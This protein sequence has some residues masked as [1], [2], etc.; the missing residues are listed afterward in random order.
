[1]I[2]SLDLARKNVKKIKFF[3]ALTNRWWSD[4]GRRTLK[5]LDLPESQRLAK[6]W[7]NFNFFTVP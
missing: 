2:R 4:K 1:M 3:G 5:A 7:K 6:A